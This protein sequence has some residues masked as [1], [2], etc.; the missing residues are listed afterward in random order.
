MD[1]RALLAGLGCA[2]AAGRV[3]AAPQASI[4]H[5][6]QPL[7]PNLIDGLMY[8]PGYRL[9]IELAGELRPYDGHWSELRSADLTL[10]ASFHV[11]V[12]QPDEVVS[13]LWWTAAGDW[14]LEL[15]ATLDGAVERRLYVGA[16]NEEAARGEARFFLS[17]C[18]DR[19][20]E[21]IDLRTTYFVN[22]GWGVPPV[23]TYTRWRPV[24]QRI[25]QS[26]RL[27]DI[28]P[29][30]QVLREMAIEMEF[31]GFYPS[32]VGATI[33]LTPQTPG[34]PGALG[35]R[36]SS[37][38]M[39]EPGPIPFLPDNPIRTREDL[40]DSFA[41]LVLRDPFTGAVGRHVS[42]HGIE[43]FVPPAT[44][45]KAQGYSFVLATGIGATRVAG[46]TASFDPVQRAATMAAF[47]AAMTSY[48]LLV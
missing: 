13:E 27:R 35:R 7:P 32:G 5:P 40:I 11:R 19:W 3:V 25:L 41:R 37:I 21:G 10:H 47:D 42:S 2:L 48:R 15:T 43:W 1:R 4:D 16:D 22:G 26:A 20:Y 24:M 9:G 14:R 34:T 6:P 29:I 44:E 33:W 12:A 8:P 45:V 31:G 46:L 28:V 36:Q 30:S 18:S 38:M 17:L 23:G 39:G